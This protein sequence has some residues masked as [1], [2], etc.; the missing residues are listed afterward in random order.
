MD[1][2]ARRRADSERRRL[3]VL[4]A[5]GECFGEEG[6]QRCSVDSI[7]ERAGVSKGL[8]FHFFKSKRGLFE[9]VMEDCLNQWATLSE[10]RASGA[11][12]NTL[13]EL[14]RL[15]LTSFDFVARNPV[16]AMFARPEE[17]V[18]QGYRKKW[19]TSP[20]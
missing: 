15:F 17:E 16:L 10:Y 6:Y 9:A 4:N 12:D 20:L 14:R 1:Y 5:A 7:A 3:A 2:E 19:K 18:I 11:Q 13:E 8:V